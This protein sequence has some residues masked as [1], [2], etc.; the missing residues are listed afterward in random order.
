MP[1]PEN[2]LAARLEADRKALLDLSLRN[3]LLNYKPRARG[4]EFVGESPEQ[5]AR[6]LLREGRRLTFL[7]APERPATDGEAEPE[8]EPEPAPAADQSDHK[9]Q[10]ALGAEPLQARLLSVYYASRASVEEQG[11]NTLFLALGMLR[12]SDPAPG[13]SSGS[14]AGGGLRAPLVLLPVVLE[15]SSARERF[16]LRYSGE[17]LQDNLSL[18]AKLKAGF[19]VDLPEPPDASGAGDDLGRYFDEVDAAVADRDGWS[20]DRASAVLGFFSFGRFLMYRDLDPEVWP[21]HARPGEHPVLRSL[22]G[23]GFGPPDRA[24]DDA[25]DVDLDRVAPPESALHVVDADA[26]QSLALWDVARGK[27]LVIQGPPGTGKSQTITNLIAAAVGRGQTVLF[28]AEKLAA[29]EVVK[30]RLDANGVGDACLELHSRA[31]SKRAVLE[32]LERTFRLGRPRAAGAGAESGPALLAETRARLNA[33][34]AALHTPVGAGGVTPYQAFGE[35]ARPGSGDFRGLPVALDLPDWPDRTA[36]ERARRLALAAEVEASVAALGVPEDHPFWGCRRADWPPSEADRLRDRLDAASQAL[37]R[38]KAASAALAQA[39]NVPEPAD[40]AGAS[41]LLRATRRVAKSGPALGVDVASPDWLA[42][43]AEVQELLDA[44]HGLAALH[45]KYDAALLPDAWRADLDDARRVLNVEGRH[46]WRF[47]SGPYREAVRRVDGLARGTPPKTLDERLALAD[48]VLDARR[49]RETVRAHE[50]LA[51]RLFASRWQGER[52]SWE[53]LSGLAKW[54]ARLHHDVRA[55]T[56]PEGVVGYLAS[57]PSLASLRPLAGAL[58]MALDGHAGAVRSLAEILAFDGGGRGPLAARAFA[59]QETTLALWASRPG[60]MP[61]LSAFNRLSARGRDEGLGAVVDLAERWDDAGTRLVAAVER[62]GAQSLLRRAFAE[63]P[64]LAG[65][66]AGGHEQAVRAF[67][68]LDREALRGNRARVALAHWERL[69]RRDP[70]AQGQLGVLRREFEKKARHFPV[71]QLLRRAGRAVQAIKPVFLMSPLSVAAYLAPGELA[72]DLVVFDEASQVRP[73]DALGAI[74]RGKQ[75]VVVGDSR[76]LPPTRFFDRLTGGEV[77]GFD[78]DPDDDDAPDSS[79]VESLLGLFVAAGSP[80]R[81]LRWHYRSRHESLI[82]VANREFYGGR[83]VVFPSPDAARTGSGLVLRYLPETVYGRGKTRTNPLE[84]GA[85]ARAVMDHARAQT[86]RPEGAQQTL[87]VAAFSVAQSLAV[88][89]HL[90]ALRKADPSTEP[91]FEPGG[92][93]PFF[94][95]NL[96][97][98]QGD[99]RDVIFLSVGYGRTAKGDVP[100]AFGPLN[101]DGGERRLNVLITRA[102]VRCE[103]FTN[104]KA[105]DVDLT[106]TRS[107]GVEALRAFLAYAE[108]GA[109]AP[110]ATGGAPALTGFDAAVLS[111]LER[112][113]LP[114][115]AV[116]GEPG[117][118]PEVALAD[119]DRPGH[120]RL[121]LLTDGPGPPG[122]R[123]A[124]DRERLRPQVL[125]ALGWRLRRVYSADWVANPAAA[126]ER[127]KTADADAP[128][129]PDEPPAPDPSP[130]LARD[131][132]NGEIPTPSGAEPYTLAAVDGPFDLAA[133]PADVIADRLDAV[134]RA[135]GPVH[136]DEAARRLADGAGVKRVGPRA[137]AAIDEALAR[138]V[139]RGSVRLVGDFLW[140]DG[141]THPIVRD[142]SALPPGA[143]KLDLV[144]PEELEAAV[145]AVVAG[146]LGMPAD[147]VPPAACR[148]LGFPRTTDEMRSRVDAAVAAL[149]AAGRLTPRGDHLITDGPAAA[150][151]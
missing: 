8:P 24:G 55:R 62:A 40:R 141:L 52:S 89:E 41:A 75:A 117:F 136:R 44:G 73:V 110:A 78:L 60:E 54:A 115:R 22:L 56:L 17:D 91:F 14:S 84:A 94:V 50:P 71:R 137:H 72:F 127:V 116:V 129:L 87:G 102:R 20:V 13:S 12:W 35:L 121:G 38:L 43:R 32:E 53:A 95:K 143:R 145:L 37:T 109:P 85:V 45:Q 9:L 29:L 113:G 138:S 139:A 124:R 23:D 133:G 92:P 16:R 64:A 151:A 57:R 67:D 66:D 74:L 3:P 105:A 58:K 132:S 149:V 6:C 98:V 100:L 107:R 80:E 103:V 5:V 79:E 1:N 96:E 93:E 128:A 68:T 81:M 18:A 70:G 122:P 125:E 77:D 144:A 39:I 112:E 118:A 26:T 83:L 86:A 108:S 61:A 42:L 65:F 48:A 47:L 28:V 106:R 27:S 114:A 7:P 4:L 140:P 33:Y 147:E 97:N 63:R 36:V 11:V 123:P 49:L 46:W 31:T 34:D 15:R 142:R 119:P 69:P 111:A 120:D 131:E 130:P 82:A 135:E 10:T 2:P 76:Q 21:A 99:E 51:A 150:G 59:A 19:G 88:L 90:E 126:L 148:L 101:A 134:V 25:E 30:R 146:S 104:L